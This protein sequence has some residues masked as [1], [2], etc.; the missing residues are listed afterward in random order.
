MT[1]IELRN[2]RKK[3]SSIHRASGD[4]KPLSQK[5][6]AQLLGCS[7]D[8][9]KKM[10][11]GKKKIPEDFEQRI[12]ERFRLYMKSGI[13]LRAMIDYLRLSF[14]GTE[15]KTVIKKVL[16]MDLAEFDTRPT[17][18]YLFD[19]LSIRGN[20][21]VFWHSR[22]TINENVLV[23][24]SGQG[25]RE[26]EE[27]MREQKMNWRTWLYDIWKSQGKLEAG[28]KRVQC[29]RFDIALDELWGLE[30]EEHFDLFE[31]L[32]KQKA[33]LLEMEFKRFQN[34]GGCFLADGN[35]RNEGLSL[36]FGSRKSPL[37]FNFYEKRFEIANREKI[38]EI[39]ALV[40]YGI[41]NRYELRLANEKA[42]R[43]LEEFILGD[44]PKRL[45]EIGVGLINK[46][47]IVWDRLESDARIVDERWAKLFRSMEELD[48]T[49]E[50]KK[51][52]L[53]RS[54]RWFLKQ[55]APTL[56]L[57]QEA[58]RILGRNF[59]EEGIR[60]AELNEEQDSYLRWMRQSGGKIV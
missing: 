27:I 38:S 33:G 28:Y 18:L 2:Y 57:L 24:F 32:E 47:L 29:S 58:D 26:Y 1:P 12:K 52:S 15:H 51:F 55:V 44:S 23:Q 53:D 13:D 22:K 3:L 46:K 43:A 11:Q 8:Y 9:I 17:G 39:E 56:K 6:F 30:T 36:Y 19:R 25:C 40:K 54:E 5:R 4:K 60:E 21:W 42:T 10:E 14:F 35:L 50:P 31:L 59:V 34:I 48:F 7:V 45:G 49:V 20:I 37:F 16:K 41:Y